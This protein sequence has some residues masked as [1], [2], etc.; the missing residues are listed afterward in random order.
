ML[1]LD[2][3]RHRLLDNQSDSYPAGHL[4]LISTSWKKSRD[5]KDPNALRIFEATKASLSIREARLLALGSEEWT[6][7]KLN[8]LVRYD[9]NVLHNF[10]RLQKYDRFGWLSASQKTKFKS[11]K[12]NKSRTAK[13]RKEG[14]KKLLSLVHDFLELFL[15]GRGGNTTNE[16]RLL[17]DAASA[18]NRILQEL[19]AL[20]HWKYATL[21]DAQ[22]AEPGKYGDLLETGY[23]VASH[24][25]GD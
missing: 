4:S 12:D 21:K 18:M 13:T 3:F 25:T 9:E 7:E 10:T 17:T 2:G 19:E 11:L 8:L 14:A 22:A 5:N 20:R 15:S 1:G 24:S 6:T 16:S 23:S